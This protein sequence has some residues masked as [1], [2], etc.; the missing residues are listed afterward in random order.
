MTAGTATHTA[1]SHATATTDH[2]LR[3]HMATPTAVHHVMETTGHMRRQRTD[4]PTVVH[5]ATAT[6]DRVLQLLTGTHTAAPHATATTGTPTLSMPTATRA[7]CAQMMP[8]WTEQSISVLFGWDY[9]REPRWLQYS[10]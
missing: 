6:T 4:T 7:E 5:H 10:R 3:Q 1:E 9:N 8:I 2:V